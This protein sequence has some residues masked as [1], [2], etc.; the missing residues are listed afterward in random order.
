[1]YLVKRAYLY[2]VKQKTKTIL[3]FSLFFIIANIVLSGLLIQA[4][5]EKTKTDIRNQ[6]GATA[7]YTIHAAQY[8]ADIRSGLIDRTLDPALLPGVPTVKNAIALVE[9]PEILAVDLVASYQVFAPDYVTFENTTLLTNNN[10]KDTTDILPYDVSLKTFTSMTPSDFE[11]SSSKLVSGR[12]ATIDELQAGVNVGIIETTFALNNQLNL[13]DTIT[14]LSADLQPVDIV[15]IGIYQSNILIDDRI[16]RTTSSSLFPQNQIYVP[17][18]TLS[19]LG[20]TD[21]QIDNYTLSKA[22][23]YLSDPQHLQSFSL[24]ANQTLNLTYGQ[25][26]LNDALYNQLVTPINQLSYL[27]DLLVIIV[28]L[29]GA[30]ILG[31][32]TALTI[33]QRKNEIGVLLAIGESRIKII[34]QFIV[35]VGIIIAL[36]FLASTF[37]GSTIGTVISQ[38]VS[39]APQ[40]TQ[41]TQQP[42]QRGN[43]SRIPGATISNPNPTVDVDITM[44]VQLEFSSLIRLFSIG[45]IITM[46]GVIIP[47]IHITRF[48]PKQILNNAI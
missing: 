36:A 6:L 32:V 26:D 20:L 1:M 41:T 4:A 46:L 15:I 25:I 13:N 43:S 12:F 45:F 24:W 29:A 7:T 31:L 28:I 27:S 44:D 18:S 11:D 17:F 39:L 9:Y 8:N 33:S 3:L 19:S 40:T 21:D 5:T 23:Y 42:A 2:L 34:S 22:I 38:Q 35:E 16:A 37:T 48:K 10:Q 47:A 30:G 14:V